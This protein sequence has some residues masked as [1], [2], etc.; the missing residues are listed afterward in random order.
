MPMQINDPALTDA[1]IR[2]VLIKLLIGGG[3]PAERA[4]PDIAKQAAG[5]DTLPGTI[6]PSLLPRPNRARPAGARLVPVNR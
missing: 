2:A 1:R 6:N 5:I 4:L 3:S